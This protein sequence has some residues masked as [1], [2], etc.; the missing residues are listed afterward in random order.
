MATFQP[1]PSPGSLS[2]TAKENPIRFLPQLPE[3][4]AKPVWSKSTPPFKTDGVLFDITPHAPGGS[5]PGETVDSF[6]YVPTFAQFKILLHT[7]FGYSLKGHSCQV[8]GPGIGQSF[9]KVEAYVQE[10]CFKFK[11]Y[12]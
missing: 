3:K 10:S 4:R 5:P 2:A 8:S 6:V 1:R 11:F 7:F 12:K 9:A